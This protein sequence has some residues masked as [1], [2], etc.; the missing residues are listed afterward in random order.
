MANRADP[1][2][3]GFGAVVSQCCNIERGRIKI[4]TLAIARLTVVSPTMTPDRLESLRANKFPF[5]AADPG[6]LNLFHIGEHKRLGPDEWVVDYNQLF[7]VA[8]TDADVFLA[9]KVLQM[10]DD[11]RIR[12]KMKLGAAL[13]RMTE[14]ELDL[15]HP[16]LAEPEQGAP[17]QPP[18]A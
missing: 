6:N 7:S 8:A 11:A 2:R 15:G 16:W 1:V 17:G 12:F 10:D 9:H 14:E 13:A 18:A 3:F 4:H 5:N